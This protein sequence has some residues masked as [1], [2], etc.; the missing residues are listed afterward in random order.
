M[1]YPTNP[2]YKIASFENNHLPLISYVASKKKPMIV[3]TGM[4]SIREIS[5][6]VKTTKKFGCKNFSNNGREEK[7]V[8][9]VFLL[10]LW[11]RTSFM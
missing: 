7:V 4:A 10:I 8:D 5:E 11:I 1:A 6:I 3:S 2:I 9:L